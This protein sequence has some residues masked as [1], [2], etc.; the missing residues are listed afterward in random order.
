MDH[1]GCRISTVGDR[2]A[3]HSIYYK[4]MKKTLTHLNNVCMRR[5]LRMSRARNDTHRARDI[6]VNKR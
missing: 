6:V 1:G 5:A 2:H 3:L 4:A